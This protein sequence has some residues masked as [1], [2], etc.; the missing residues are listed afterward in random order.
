MDVS[1]GVGTWVMH[2][3]QIQTQSKAKTLSR[4]VSFVY[5]S[6]ISSKT[7]ASAAAFMKWIQAV[8]PF[9][10]ATKCDRKLMKD[11]HVFVWIKHILSDVRYRVEL[12]WGYLRIKQH[13]AV[14]CLCWRRLSMA[15]AWVAFVVV[16]ADSSFSAIRTFRDSISITEHTLFVR[17]SI[18]R[19]FERQYLNYEIE[20][21]IL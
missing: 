14:L 13:G 21:L 19:F 9:H 5:L 10:G 6:F 20:N 17:R 1:W 8:W 4:R 3:P 18:W 7:L 12:I 15:Y 11:M 16:A 2:Q